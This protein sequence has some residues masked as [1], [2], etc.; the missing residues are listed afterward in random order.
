MQELPHPTHARTTLKAMMILLV[1][2]LVIFISAFYF[3]NNDG[4]SIQSISF[5][6]AF[7]LGGAL[8]MAIAILR[9]YICKC[10]TCGSW[11]TEQVKVDT[12]AYSRKFVCQQCKIMWDSKVK[13]TT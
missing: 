1:L 5:A 13:L 8:F 2:L 3:N 6:V 12:D 7:I 4:S 10:A 9:A 11:L